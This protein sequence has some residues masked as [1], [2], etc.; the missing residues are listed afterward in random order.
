MHPHPDSGTAFAGQTLDAFDFLI[1]DFG[2]D[3][4]H[5]GP[6][7]VRY[8]S[9]AAFVEILRDQQTGGIDFSVGLLEADKRRERGFTLAQLL[10]FQGDL[11]DVEPFF[12]S[13]ERL[14]GLVCRIAGHALRAERDFFRRL[15]EFENRRILE[16]VREAGA[17]EAGRE[18]LWEN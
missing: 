14:T 12:Q 13:D 2:F 17:G 7:R 3:P 6:F 4:T 16:R 18:F 9:S 15:D 8:E 5:A 10:F 11:D 1:R